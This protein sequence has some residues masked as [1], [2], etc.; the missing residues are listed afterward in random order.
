VESRRRVQGKARRDVEVEGFAVWIAL[1]SLTVA[2]GESHHS[3]RMR[4][5]EVVGFVGGRDKQL[6]CRL[7]DACAMTHAL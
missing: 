7:G 1:G 2:F 4:F 6:V 5:D 3:G